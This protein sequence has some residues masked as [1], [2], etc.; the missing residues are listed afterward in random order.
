MRTVLLIFAVLL[1]LLTLLSTFGG[2]LR[3][4]ESFIEE[5][6]PTFPEAS[7]LP[8][9]PPTLQEYQVPNITPPAQQPQPLK[10]IEGFEIAPYEKDEKEEFASF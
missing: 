2:S 4:G 1:I 5:S 3:T 7:T 9:M 8:P 6:M 10:A